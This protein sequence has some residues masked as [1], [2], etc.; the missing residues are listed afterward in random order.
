MKI[1]ML[2]QRLIVYPVVPIATS[3]VRGNNS[4]S[5]AQE[6]DVCEGLVMYPDS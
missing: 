5:S 1:H 2:N 4:L 6:V 3:S